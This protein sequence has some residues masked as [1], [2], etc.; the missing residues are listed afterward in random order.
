MDC[1]VLL[2]ELQKKMGDCTACGLCKTRQ[3]IVFGSGAA[4]AAIMLIGEGPGADED[5]LGQPFVGKAGQLLDKII[6]AAELPPHQ[7]YICNVVKC[8]P[9]GNRLPSP[10]EAAICKGFLREQIRI[11]EPLIIV[12]LGALASQTVL[13]DPQMRITRDRG[14][15][16]RKGQF[17]IMPTFHPAALL[18]DQSKKR[19]VWQDFQA[20]AAKYKELTIN[21]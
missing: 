11:V 21:Q 15:W 8:R 13:N 6:Q 14:Q 18:R 7:L 3:N 1:R 2:T 16:R 12:C 5:R 20:V 9:P 19:P 17:W 4:T 10:E